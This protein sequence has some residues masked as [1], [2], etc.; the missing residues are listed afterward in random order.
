MIQRETYALVTREG[1]QDAVR[2]DR[3]DENGKLE[4]W[5]Y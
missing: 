2:K 1:R 3:D 5:Y 4:A